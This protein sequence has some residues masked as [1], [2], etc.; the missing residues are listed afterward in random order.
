MVEESDFVKHP[1]LF[2]D[3]EYGFDEDFDDGPDAGAEA[4][5][6]LEDEAGDDLYDEDFG[7]VTAGETS[8]EGE[9]FDFDDD[10]DADFS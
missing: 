7:K 5:D 3:I 10:M 1:S 2:A 9:E 8:P 6:P 4:D